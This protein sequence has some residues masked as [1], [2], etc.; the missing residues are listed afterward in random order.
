LNITV[1]AE[2]WSSSSGNSYKA[3]RRNE[4]FEQA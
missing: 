2:F 3:D 1:T 4:R